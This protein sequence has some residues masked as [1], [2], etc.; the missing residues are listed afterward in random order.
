LRNNPRITK[1]ELMY[2]VTI[3]QDHKLSIQFK[4]NDVWIGEESSDMD[5][6]PVDEKSFQVMHKGGSYTVHVVEQLPEEK[7]VILMINGKKAKL[8][9]TTELDRLLKS[10][11]L[12]NA[13]ASKV[14]NLKA[15]MPGLIHSISV[16]AGQEVKKGDALLILEAMKME[17]IIKSPTDGTIAKIHI[18]KGNTVDKGQL[19]V[20]FD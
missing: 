19:M 18:E 12:E 4:G 8:S 16:E 20:S 14:S 11:G 7:A 1:P 6:I 10:M 17:N 9:I 5:V 3:N 2:E 13:A 15:P